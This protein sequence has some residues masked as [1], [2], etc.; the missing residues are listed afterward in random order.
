VRGAPLQ[1][2]V[3]PGPRVRQC[4]GTGST[5]SPGSVVLTVRDAA[6]AAQPTAVPVVPSTVNTGLGIVWRE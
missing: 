1:A 3:V 6:I 2:I 5:S 4:S